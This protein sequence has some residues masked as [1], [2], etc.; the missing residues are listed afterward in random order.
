MALD[1][2]E[3]GKRGRENAVSPAHTQKSPRA[4]SRVDCPELACL[5]GWLSEHTIAEAHRRASAI[6]TGADRV[7]IGAGLLD[8]DIYLRL[9]AG[10]LGIAFD[11]LDATLR[12]TCPLDD[13]RLIEAPSAGLLPLNIGGELKLVVA[14]RDGS[15]RRLI[16]IV[17]SH[18]DLAKQFRLTTAAR[19]QT[20][21]SRHV[22]I[23]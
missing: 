13:A 4:S 10:S 16:E 19:L 11:P 14:P 22:G 3:L 15:A 21:V 17:R 8:E 9:L 7:L 6:G 23:A 18:P 1:V 5:R 2:R 20:F 12:E